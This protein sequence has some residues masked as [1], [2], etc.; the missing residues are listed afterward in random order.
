MRAR[1]I[2][3]ALTVSSIVSV[4]LLQPVQG[5]PA[6]RRATAGQAASG[7]II[8]EGGGILRLNTT[9]CRDTSSVLVFQK[10]YAKEHAG[11]VNCRGARRSLVQVIQR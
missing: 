3:A 7:Q 9:P 10:P 2:A 6:E 11:D 1:L 8:S 4:A 5:Q